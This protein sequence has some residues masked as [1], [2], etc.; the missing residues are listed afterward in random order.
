MSDYRWRVSELMVLIWNVLEHHPYSHEFGVHAVYVLQAAVE[1]FGV[2]FTRPV[3]RTPE[4]YLMRIP[5]MDPAA[6]ARVQGDLMTALRITLP[7]TEGPPLDEE[8]LVGTISGPILSVMVAERENLS[9]LADQS[10]S[11]IPRR[12]RELV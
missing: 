6:A 3:N 12:H 2:E 10:D 4:D 8:R 1:Q 11:Y 9:T 7:W 5:G